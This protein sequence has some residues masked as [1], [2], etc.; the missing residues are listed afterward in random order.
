[1]L[2]INTLNFNYFKSDNNNFYICNPSFEIN[3][4]LLYSKIYSEL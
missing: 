2:N 1:M 4:N 3:S